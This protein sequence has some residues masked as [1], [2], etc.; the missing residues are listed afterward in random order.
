MRIA[1]MGSGGVG[2]LVGSQLVQAGEDVVFIARGANLEALHT[3]GL[4]VKSQTFGDF[5]SPVTATDDTAS[6]GVVDLVVFAVK[7]YDT[8]EAVA[9][10]APLIGPGTMVLPLQNGIDSVERL[11]RVISPGALVGG[12][13]YLVATRVGPGEIVHQGMNRIVVGEPSGGSSPR[14][15]RLRDLFKR[16][17]ILVE[18]SA[19]WRVPMW[20]KFVLLAATGGVMA[21]TRLPIGPIRDCPETFALFRGAIEEA[22]AVARSQ[23]VL[24]ADDCVDRHLTTVAGLNPAARSSM[25]TDILA[26]RRLELEALNGAVV[27]LGAQGGVATPLNFAVYAAL[28]PYANGALGAAPAT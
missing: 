8:G 23:G 17:R 25:L 22:V 6:I 20:E 21:L 16:T 19:N 1:I 10:M 28:R 18:V 12:I 24:L 2:G 26:G 15:E 13:A 7:T 4:S 11:A 5:A 9:R 3:R 14:L 27:R